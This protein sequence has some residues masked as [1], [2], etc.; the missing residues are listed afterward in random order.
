[1]VIFGKYKS[2]HASLLPE[3][4]ADQLQSLQDKTCASLKIN[5]KLMTALNTFPDP[6]LPSFP[7]QCLLPLSH[8][9]QGF[10]HSI[11]FVISYHALL[12]PRTFTCILSA[13]NMQYLSL[14]LIFFLRFYLFIHERHRQ[15]E[16]Q[17]PVSYTHLTLPT[18]CRG[19]RSRWS[20]YH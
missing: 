4:A 11:L 1:M 18:T 15:R 3:S 7:L 9:I 2:N 13:C 10:S 16:K 17:A 8:T 12:S 5:L 6:P 19:C 20:P 14:T